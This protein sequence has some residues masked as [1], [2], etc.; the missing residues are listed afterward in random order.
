MQ[1]EFIY[2]TMSHH[3]EILT[4]II[5]KYTDNIL[6]CILLE[7]W[8]S[9][10][11]D[12]TDVDNWCGLDAQDLFEWQATNKET[13]ILNVYLVWREPGTI[14]DLKALGWL[15]SCNLNFSGGGGAAGKKLVH[16]LSTH[17]INVYTGYGKSRNEKDYHYFDCWMKGSK[18][19]YD[20]VYDYFFAEFIAAF[21]FVQYEWIRDVL[22]KD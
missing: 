5:N 4:T 20:K 3:V 8:W 9:G 6:G 13:G 1:L 19:D 16:C 11:E 15:Q 22:N 18:A 7:T 2:P 21:R 10:H 12:E 17:D 14:L